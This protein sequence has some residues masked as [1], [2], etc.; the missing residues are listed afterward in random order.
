[1]FNPEE[2]VMKQTTSKEL[3]TKFKSEGHFFQ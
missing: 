3:F 1:M 2:K